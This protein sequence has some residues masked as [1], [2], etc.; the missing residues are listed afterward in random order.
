MNEIRLTGSVAREV[1][2]LLFDDLNLFLEVMNELA[3]FLG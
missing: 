2:E 3:Y 1:F